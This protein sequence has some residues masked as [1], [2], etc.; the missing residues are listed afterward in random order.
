MFLR[1]FGSIEVPRGS[2]SAAFFM[3]SGALL[4]RLSAGD[5]HATRSGQ[6]RKMRRSGS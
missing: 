1:F 5:R 3:S 4:R 2:L 6:P